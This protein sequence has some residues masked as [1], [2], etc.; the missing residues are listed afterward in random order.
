MPHIEGNKST[1]NWDI[2]TLDTVIDIDQLQHWSDEVTANYNKLW[3]NFSKKDYIKDK[4]KNKD[5]D[6]DGHGGGYHLKNLME[7]N[8]QNIDYM[9]LSWPCEKDIPC[10]PVW[11]GKEDIYPELHDGSEYKI[12]KKFYYGYFKKL[13][14]QLGEKYFARASLIRHQ[15]KT[16]L[17]KHID[18]P[19][20]VRLHIPIYCN[21]GSKFLYG[22]N[23]EREHHLEVG[24]AYL[25]NAGVPHGTV[26][27]D[28]VRIHLQTKVKLEDI[29]NA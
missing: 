15:P 17:T 29:V 23:L 20:I 9:E 22:D 19:G 25:I 12:Q 3:F 4:Y 2:M 13:I 8:V 14:D 27:G 6:F 11:A 1:M 5:F 21:K 24:K 10:P 16:V 28:E 18:G 26:N 7:D